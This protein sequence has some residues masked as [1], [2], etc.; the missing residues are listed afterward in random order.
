M[1]QFTNFIGTFQSSVIFSVITLT[2]KWINVIFHPYYKHRT[3][4]EILYEIGYF[5]QGFQ[6]TFHVRPFH[7]KFFTFCWN[8]ILE[9]LILICREI[10]DLQSYPLS[11]R[12]QIYTELRRNLHKQVSSCLLN[13]SKHSAF[14]NLLY[15]IMN[16]LFPNTI[17]DHMVISL[18]DFTLGNITVLPTVY[19]S[20]KA[21]TKFFY[22]LQRWSTINYC[23][24]CVDETCHLLHARW[25]KLNKE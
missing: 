9:K 8:P 25:H 21:G 13:C 1:A 7:I 10:P 3:L 20:P 14:V 23:R 15:I 5:V 22:T 16:Y 24:I 6:W 4:R 11:W 17:S 12:N 18:L 2:F 19:F